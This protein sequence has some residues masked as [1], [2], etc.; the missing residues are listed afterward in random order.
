VASGTLITGGGTLKAGSLI[1]ASTVQASGGTLS[2][3]GGIAGTDKLDIAA[4]STLSLSGSESSGQEAIF[5]SA[6]S[7]LVLGAP[8]A[9]AGTIY[10]FIKGDTIDLSN[11]LAS[12]LTYSGQ[13]LT[14]H[15]GGGASL[16]LKLAGSDSQTGFGTT[17]D[18]HGG[19]LITHS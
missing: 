10:N 8:T 11:I 18:G 16:A 4:T 3:V 7:K 15:E 12:S 9:F 6:I 1:N 14:V 13:M 5:R 19:T 2:F 17:S